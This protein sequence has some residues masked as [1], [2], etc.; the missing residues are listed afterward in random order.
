VEARCLRRKIQRVFLKRKSKEKTTVIEESDAK[1][2]H[3]FL[4]LAGFQSLRS[5]TLRAPRKESSAE[6]W[7]W[8]HRRGSWGHSK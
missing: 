3:L 6:R 4:I 5:F 7:G 8:G 1:E 2:K